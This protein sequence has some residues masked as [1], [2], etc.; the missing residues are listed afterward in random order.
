MDRTIVYP[1]A[2]PLDTDLLTIQRN[3]MVSLG[4]LA[5]MALGSGTIVDGLACTP[6]SPASLVVQVGGGA[7]TQLST[8]DQNAFGSLPA[9]LS[10]LVKIGVSLQTQSFTLTAPT[11]SGQSINYL[12][13]A[14]L[15]EADV[16]PVVLPYYNASNPA[17]P[18]SGPT[19]SGVAQNT[20]RVQVV[21][22]QMKV[23]AAAPSGAQATPPVDTGWVGLYVI[24]VNYGQTQ[25]GLSNIVQLQ[26]APFVPFKLP[27]LRPGFST[28]QVFST[29]GNFSV[30]SGVTICK[31]TVIGG[32]GGGGWHAS[33]P[34]GGGGAGGQAVKIVRGLTPG[35]VVPVTVG[36]AGQPPAAAGND[37]SPGGTSSFGTWASATGGAGG[38]GTGNLSGGAGGN[39]YGGDVNLAGS[40]GTDGLSIANHGGD[41]GGPGGARGVTGALPGL[42]A[43]APGGGGGGG[44]GAGSGIGYPGGAGAGG[45]VMV[46]Y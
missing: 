15:Q 42:S 35:V 7:I 23:G 45:L 29:S 9:D 44:G 16:S 39:G 28:I 46:E 5:A 1:G 13:Q 6:T 11:T 34:S 10:P 33:Q 41:G 36:A 26:T 31:A 18:Y 30:P 38:Q 40:Y 3:A 27:S 32:G 25:I 19:N 8:V 12:I 4:A 21:Q 2:I 37:G 43:P 20:K 14:T 17:Q 22:L 24:T